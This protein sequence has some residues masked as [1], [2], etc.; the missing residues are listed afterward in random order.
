MQT[1]K[2]YAN[3]CNISILKDLLKCKDLQ[4][5]DKSVVFISADNVESK[6][7]FSYAVTQRV[8]S[9]FTVHYK[10][11]HTVWNMPKM[12]AWMIHTI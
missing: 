11:F 1:S 4:I 9:R 10:R 2:R 8:Y 12:A 7:V 3:D 6:T 5:T